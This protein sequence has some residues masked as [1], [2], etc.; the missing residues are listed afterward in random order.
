MIT[1]YLEPSSSGV[2][3]SLLELLQEI[4]IQASS[5]GHTVPYLLFQS[6]TSINILSATLAGSCKVTA[7]PK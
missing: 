7:F 3:W 6:V 1:S 4:R 5:R 2:H